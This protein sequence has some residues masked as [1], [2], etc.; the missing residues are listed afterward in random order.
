MGTQHAAGVA[1][2]HHRVQSRKEV[3][4][5][6]KCIIKERT[7]KAYDKACLW[8]FGWVI[9]WGLRLPSETWGFDDLVCAGIECLWEEGENRSVAGNLISGLQHATP[10]LSGCLKGSWRLWNAWGRAEIPMRAPPLT[11]E[12]VKSLSYVLLMWDCRDCA[13]LLL[14]GFLSFLR[15]SEFLSIRRQD[16]TFAT[17]LRRMHINL[18]STK[19]VSRSGGIECVYIA[20]EVVVKAIFNFCSDLLPG[21]S[22]LHRTGAQFRKVFAAAVLECGLDSGIRP[23]SLRRGG[24]T[25]HFRRFGNMDK[26]MEIGRWQHQKTARVYVNSALAELAVLQLSAGTISRVEEWSA[27]LSVVL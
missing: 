4:P 2:R 16:L 10:P 22:I 19:G 7:K 27:A 20:D 8:F 6:K 17:D 11:W 9:A 3:G 1:S 15:T 18:P 5:L 23:Y 13:L 24:A 12:M 25:Y 14:I 26:T 21:D